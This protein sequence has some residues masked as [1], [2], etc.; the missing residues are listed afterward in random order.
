VCTNQAC[1]T[2][3]TLRAEVM[4]NAVNNGVQGSSKADA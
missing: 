4:S 2:T 1:S 3:G